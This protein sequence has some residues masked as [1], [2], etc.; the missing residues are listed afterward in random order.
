[1]SNGG[2]RGIKQV[3][4]HTQNNGFNSAGTTTTHSST[5]TH[6]K[7][8]KIVL[9]DKFTTVLNQSTPLGMVDA[10]MIGLADWI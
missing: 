7:L 10:A 3:C 4:M 1:M 2:E 8:I 6:K 5:W 9:I